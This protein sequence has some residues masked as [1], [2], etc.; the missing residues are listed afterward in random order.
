MK[1]RRI[2]IVSL[3]FGAIALWVSG[4][5]FAVFGARWHANN[6]HSGT[7]ANITGVGI[8]ESSYSSVFAGIGIQNAPPNQTV[9]AGFQ[10]GELTKN[11]D[12]SDCANAGTGYMA[13]REISGT[14]YCDFFY[15]NPISFGSNHRFA[16]LYNTT[17]GGWCAYMDGN[18]VD[19]PFTNIGMGGAGYAA[20]R[21]ELY[22]GSLEPV[23]D[24][25]YG[26]SG[27]TPWQY[28]NDGGQSYTTIGSSSGYKQDPLF[29]MSGTPSPFE[30]YYD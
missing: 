2:V 3:A 4:S 10:T 6:N 23:F 30:I 21:G 25:T 20:A 18:L 11:I 24:M 28:T 15:Q 1:L 27:Y 16:V 7:R 13:E 8:L 22:Y 19:G 26:P 29:S 17:C 12:G 5:A 14:L 9:T